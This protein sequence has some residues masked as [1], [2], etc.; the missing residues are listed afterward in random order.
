MDLLANLT[1]L[2]EY[3]DDGTY[4]AQFEYGTDELRLEMLEV[5]DL[6]FEVA[7][8]V[9]EILTELMVRKGLGDPGKEKSE[10]EAD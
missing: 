8:K 1:K 2:N 5:A 6:L 9:E 10:K 4:Q 3:L 7:E